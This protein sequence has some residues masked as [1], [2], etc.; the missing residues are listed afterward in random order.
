[1]GI[2]PKKRV[3]IKNI[4]NHHLDDGLEKV[5]PCFIE[6]IHKM[7]V[8][9]IRK[10]RGSSMRNTPTH[11]PQP[12]HLQTPPANSFIITWFSPCNMPKHNI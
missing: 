7:E 10:M 1:M 9:K 12:F 6:F 4:W 5:S 8:K 3:N 2:F 11:R